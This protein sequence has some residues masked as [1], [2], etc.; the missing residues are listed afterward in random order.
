MSEQKQVFKILDPQPNLLVDDVPQRISTESIV[1]RSVSIEAL[2]ANN[3]D[4]FITDTE[5]HGTTT[6]RHLLEPGDLIRITPEEYG[7]LDAIMDLKDLWFNSA[8]AGNKL[9]VSFFPVDVEI[10]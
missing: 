5:A 8:K 1:V 2:K 7:N 3:K 10:V 9:V 4:V 6:N